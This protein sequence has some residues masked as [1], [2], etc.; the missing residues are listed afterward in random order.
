MEDCMQESGP[1]S[2]IDEGPDQSPSAS[3]ARENDAFAGEASPS[4][5]APAPRP[6]RAADPV[7]QWIMIAIAFVVVFWLVGILSAMMFGLL[8][9]A[10]AP[11]TSTERDL[12]ILSATVDSGKANTQTYSQYI[13][14]LISAGQLAKAQ[15]ALDT[16][17]QTAKTDKSYLYAR[18]TD[19]L[20][21]K[22]DYQGTVTEA[23]KAM[24]EAKKE[25]KAVMAANV[26][27]NRAANAGV[28][29]PASYTDAALDKAEALIASKDYK[30]AIKAYDLYLAEQPIDSDILVQRAQAKIQ[31]GDNKGAEADF[32]KALTYVPDLKPALDGLK[33]IGAAK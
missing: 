7:A 12:A 16:A 10:K 18:Q 8:A 19:L 14:T 15:Q 5:T 33:Q 25:V 22:K 17:L 1:M 9:P 4:G 26:A 11:R 23:D 2:P 29:T 31:V 21:A 13:S 27:A 20:L 3:E 6:R 30:G 24:A 28:R 32:R